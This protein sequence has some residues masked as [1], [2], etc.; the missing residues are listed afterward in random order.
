MSA[1]CSQQS[2]CLK[3]VLCEASV[4]GVSGDTVCA[5][6]RKSWQGL[7]YTVRHPEVVS[8]VVSGGDACQ[9]CLAERITTSSALSHAGDGEAV[10]RGLLCTV[11]QFRVA[12][13][14]DPCQVT[15]A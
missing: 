15:L 14:G 1:A 4:C 10:V 13:S 7:L 8:G 2:L 9:G 6:P 11:R 12:H 3:L 5:V